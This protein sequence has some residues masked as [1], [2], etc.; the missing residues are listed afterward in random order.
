MRFSRKFGLMMLIAVLL[1]VP[2][3]AGCGSDD[4]KETAKS[5]PQTGEPSETVTITIG[6]LTDK[7]G[8]IANA[9]SVIDIGLEDMARYF[10]EQNLIP[11]VELEV[12]HYDGQYDPAKH[13]PGYQWLRE[14][15]ADLIYAADPNAIETLKSVVDRDE[16]VLFASSAQDILLEQ[17]GYAFTAGTH[18]ADLYYSFLDWI[19]ENDWDY[20][21]NGPAKIGLAGW[22]V[23]IEYAMVQGLKKYCND[24]PDRF[25]WEGEYLTD[26]GFI[27]EFEANALKD[28]DYVVPPPGSLVTF[29]RDYRN[30][31]GKAK[32]V[33]SDP[34]IALFSLVSDAGIWDHLD[35]T[36][37]IRESKY[38]NE[39]GE[40]IDLINKLAHDYHSPGE[41]EKITKAGVSYLSASHAY[42]MMEI[43]K[44]A[45]EAVG[46]T[47]IDSQSLYTAAQS[48][49]LN[50]DGVQVYSFT[51]T[52]RFGCDK[53]GV[54]AVSA[55][56]E[57]L[58]SVEPERLPIIIV[59]R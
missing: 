48:Y 14:K 8:P 52:K 22:A 28:C 40:L 2:L 43:I 49:M 19:A 24:H 3:L 32:F 10:N 26:L 50:I 33:G 11:G 16:V 1:A 38:W 35:E 57:T 37:I 20:A 18:P 46:P 30:A 17:A 9:L 4:E 41:L 44:S 25:E 54:Y 12:V 6:N 39:E 29:V 58:Y 21:A 5:T 59:T 51:D 7:T 13:I 27:W 23:N 55:A 31:G 34:H 53:F 36:L 56:D 45:A 47:N 42:I 15:G